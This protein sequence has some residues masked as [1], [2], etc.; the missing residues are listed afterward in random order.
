MHQSIYL[1]SLNGFIGS[2]FEKIEFAAKFNLLVKNTRRLHNL[3]VNIP[4]YFW[5]FSTS[6]C[7]YPEVVLSGYWIPRTFFKFF[8]AFHKRFFFHQISGHHYHIYKVVLKFPCNNTQA[9]STFR[10]FYLEVVKF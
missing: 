5:I 6:E 9:F 4:E 3:E 8:G 2:C 7:P 1:L 10:Y